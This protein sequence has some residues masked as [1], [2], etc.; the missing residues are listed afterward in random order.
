MTKKQLTK[1]EL[2]KKLR[3]TAT[4]SEKWINS[5]IEA[6]NSNSKFLDKELL[7]EQLAHLG[8]IQTKIKQINKEVDSFLSQPIENISLKQFKD[9]F[10]SAGMKYQKAGLEYKNNGG[11]QREAKIKAALKANKL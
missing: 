7:E 3:E 10:N 4:T 9:Q 5:S 6:L 1:P 8:I 11:P 2:V